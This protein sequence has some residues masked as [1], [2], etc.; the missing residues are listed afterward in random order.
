MDPLLVQHTWGTAFKG[1][2]TAFFS[3]NIFFFLWSTLH[4]IKFFLSF[5]LLLLLHFFFFIT[6]PING[7]TA[8][9]SG[10]RCRSDLSFFLFSSFSP[11]SSQ[12][13]KKKKKNQRLG[14][15][16][17]CCGFVNFLGASRM[18]MNFVGLC[19]KLRTEVVVVGIGGW[20]EK[21]KKRKKKKGMP[22]LKSLVLGGN[23]V[24]KWCEAGRLIG[25]LDMV[26]RYGSHKK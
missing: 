9:D 23:G 21:K 11:F 26:L 2:S 18:L 25:M 20:R 15:R 4:S 17:G 24:M 5:F 16:I 10:D 12:T 14:Q 13:H 3:T 7:A 8:G 19:F 22:G 6:D 1:L